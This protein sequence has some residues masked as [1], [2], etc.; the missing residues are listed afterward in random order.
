[1]NKISRYFEYISRF[2]K[3]FSPNDSIRIV[4]DRKE[5]EEYAL[6]N[7]TSMGVVFE[8]GQF[9]I[10]VDLVKNEAGSK[11]TYS[12]IINKNGY[13]GVVIVPIYDDK[14]L[15]LEQ[16]RHGTRQLEIELPRGFSEPAILPEEN[17]IKEVFEEIGGKIS[18]LDCCGS[19]ISDTGLTGGEVYVFICKLESIGDLLRE[20]GIEGYKLLSLEEIEEL[21]YK[22]VIRDSFTISAISKIKIYL[23]KRGSDVF[24]FI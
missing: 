15:V 24:R 2:P 17:A 9:A 14:I 16:F 7:N 1:M 22:G 21:I 12:R 5:I 23:K 11:Y 3:F 13:N 6:N 10:V 8:N 19:V 18:K 20:E 4:S